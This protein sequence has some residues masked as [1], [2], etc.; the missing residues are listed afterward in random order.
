MWHIQSVGSNWKKA[1]NKSHWEQTPIISTKNQTLIYTVA[2]NPQNPPIVDKCSSRQ[3]DCSLVV[4]TM[5]ILFLFRREC[6][7]NSTSAAATYVG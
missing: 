4:L 6:S 5:V 3:M 7:K 1:E 2:N